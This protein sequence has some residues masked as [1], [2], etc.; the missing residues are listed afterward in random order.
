MYILKQQ[1]ECKLN[2]LAHD[3]DCGIYKKDDDDTKDNKYN[4]KTQDAEYYE[5]DEKEKDDDEYYEFDSDN[6]KR[7]ISRS[8]AMACLYHVVC[9][10]YQEKRWEHNN[11]WI[12]NSDGLPLIEDWD[13]TFKKK[14]YSKHLDLKAEIKQMIDVNFGNNS[15]E[16]EAQEPELESER[17][18]KQAAKVIVVEKEGEFD[19]EY[20]AK[21]CNLDS[22]FC[23]MMYLN[24][25]VMEDI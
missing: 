7:C 17:N 14:F 18:W 20:D 16:V 25:I 13:N 15:Q 6:N 21:F 10:C 12:E 24:L 23:T 9:Q 3:S 19:C 1:M 8:D 11:R 22:I 4:N 5:E 2:L